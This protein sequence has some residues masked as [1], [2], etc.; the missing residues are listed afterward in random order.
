MTFKAALEVYPF[1][2]LACVTRGLR[3]AFAPPL[4]GIQ[5]RASGRAKRTFTRRNWRRG[6]ASVGSTV[7]GAGRPKRTPRK[8][9]AGESAGG[10]FARISGNGGSEPP[11]RNSSSPAGRAHTHASRAGTAPTSGRK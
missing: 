3:F 2:D 5:G 10:D 11:V 9:A 4:C 6:P 7:C 8:Q 1:D